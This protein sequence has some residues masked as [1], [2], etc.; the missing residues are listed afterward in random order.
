MM[1][2]VENRSSFRFPA[3]SKSHVIQT[4]IKKMK[5]SQKLPIKNP[6]RHRLL[7]FNF[8]KL[9]KGIFFQS[10]YVY[11]FSCCQRNAS[12]KNIFYV[13]NNFKVGVE[14]P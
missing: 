12:T 13:I 2:S 1:G 8:P 10:Q 6:V 11:D 3:M 4:S 14:N 9:L 5:L 7:S